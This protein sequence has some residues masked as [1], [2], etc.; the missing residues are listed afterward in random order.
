LAIS[1]LAGLQNYKE[2]T[3]SVNVSFSLIWPH[4]NSRIEIR[5][6]HAVNENN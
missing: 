3:S 5:S 1:D 6:L 2:V 4:R